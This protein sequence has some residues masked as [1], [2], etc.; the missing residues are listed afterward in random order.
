[1]ERSISVSTTGHAPSSPRTPIHLAE[2]AQHH[3]LL[4]RDPGDVK[5]DERHQEGGT[6][7]PV[8]EEEKLS[9]RPQQTGG[10]H[11]V[12]DLLA[13]ASAHQPVVRSDLEP[14][15][16]LRATATEATGPEG[17]G[18]CRGSRRRRW[19]ATEASAA[20]APL[21][22]GVQ[23]KRR[24]SHPEALSRGLDPRSR[25]SSQRPQGS[26]RLH[27]PEDDLDLPEGG[28]QPPAEELRGLRNLTYQEGR[29]SML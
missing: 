17:R 9:H 11:R 13:D 2:F 21:A 22:P 7:D 14:R 29:F 27:R 6:S 5:R 26:A 1:M 10:V 12:A 18:Q 20:W 23:L 24:P 8:L 25:N 16:G 28:Y 4:T 15:R 19:G 3:L